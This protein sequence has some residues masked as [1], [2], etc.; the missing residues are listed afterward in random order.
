MGL[1]LPSLATLG[2]LFIHIAFFGFTFSLRK[3]YPNVFSSCLFWIACC[4]LVVALIRSGTSVSFLMANLSEPLYLKISHYFDVLIPIANWTY[5]IG[6]IGWCI[7][8][9]I[10]L[11]SILKGKIYPVIQVTPSGEISDAPT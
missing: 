10:L 11:I 6:Y 3:K 8:A 9:V 2:Y 1:L 4:N 5:F 7:V